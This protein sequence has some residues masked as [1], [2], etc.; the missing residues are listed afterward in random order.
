MEDILYFDYCAI[1][2]SLVFIISMI[3]RKNYQG[4]SNHL[5]MTMLILTLAASVGDL[6]SAVTQLYAPMNTA[7]K[8]LFY[9]SNDLYFICHNLLLPIYVIYI[10]TSCGVL[11]L[12][13]RKKYLSILWLA[14]CGL[15]ILVLIVNHFVHIVYSLSPD[16]KYTRGPVIMLFYVS[17]GFF[18]IWGL[19]A[20]IRYRKLLGATKVMVLLLLY[21][22]VIVSVALQFFLPYT[23]C[24]MFAISL[25]ELEFIIVVQ[26]K[27][28]TVDPIIGA[29]KYGAGIE[30]MLNILMTRRP[31]G[32]LLVKL[33]NNSSILTYLGQDLYN[34]FLA[35]F[36]KRLHEMS[37]NCGYGGE[38]YYLEYGLYGFLGEGENADKHMELAEAIREY[39][40]RKHKF[41][42]LDVVID[43]KMCILSIPDDF[44]EFQPL[45]NFATSFHHTAPGTGDILLFSEYKNQTDF[46]IRRDLDDI[47]EKAIENGNF[48]LYYQ[49]IYSTEENRFVSAEA[50]LRLYDDRYGFIPPSLF[51]P[52]AESTGRIHQISDFV[53]NEVMKFMKE[54]NITAFGLKYIEVN[55]SSGQCIESDLVDK[56]EALLDKYELEPDQLSFELTENAAD[57][58]PAVV[59]KNVRRLH[60]LG[61]RFALDDY[62]TGYSNIKRVT[63]LPF[64]QIKLDKSFV[65]EIDDPA[66]W[67]VMQET[68]IM[69]KE[70]GKEVLVEGVEREDVAK[71]FIDLKTDLLQ[72]CEYIQGFYFCKPL[73]QD[74]FVRFLAEHRYGEVI[75]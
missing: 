70:M 1:F 52:M 21:P 13:R 3:L 69:L 19:L 57:I 18:G 59:D 67:L 58:D 4:R 74:E 2:I 68:I 30:N 49:P 20:V 45:F 28:A 43:A 75:S 55:L 39:T 24:E 65:D 62:G 11:H 71:R 15:N 47:M 23:L 48:E 34:Q 44:D 64:S 56:V 32:I 5:V 7:L 29:K 66:M 53:L 36:S 27:E 8:I 6:G 12:Y 42:N 26:N 14:V 25:A 9:I 41:E 10:Y 38:F 31:A 60:N 51:I 40:S 46:M 16:E 50:L 35:R 37:V 22:I 72:G 17:A 73:P 61:V 33:T 54:M 63:S